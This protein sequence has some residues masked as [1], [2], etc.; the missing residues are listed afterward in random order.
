MSERSLTFSD[1]VTRQRVILQTVVGL[2]AALDEIKVKTAEDLTTDDFSV[3]SVL[4]GLL[5]ASDG[6]G[7]LGEIATRKNFQI[8]LLKKLK[9]FFRVLLRTY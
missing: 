1:L 9:D 5:C 3:A 7:S 4:H 8:G 2:V 6:V